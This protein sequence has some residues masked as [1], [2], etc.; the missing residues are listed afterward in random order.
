MG[1]QGKSTT[2]FYKPGIEVWQKVAMGTD[3]NAA[4]YVWGEVRYIDAFNKKRKTRFRLI[5]RGGPEFR[6]KPLAFCDEGNG[7]D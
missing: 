3:H 4:I 7:A 1:P 2:S 6:D 5:Q